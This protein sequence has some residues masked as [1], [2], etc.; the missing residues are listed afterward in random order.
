MTR[1]RESLVTNAAS[2]PGLLDVRCCCQ[3]QKL[4]GWLPAPEGGRSRRF[5]LR[6]PY[7]SGQRWT[8]GAEEPTAIPINEVRLDVCE[9][10][11]APKNGDGSRPPWRDT[12]E[13]YKA[14]GVPLETLRLIP[15]FIEA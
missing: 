2:A 15:G 14:E 12:Q 1:T 6:S 9:F 13:A 7:P 3:P 11:D 10:F 4:L 8:D 5:V